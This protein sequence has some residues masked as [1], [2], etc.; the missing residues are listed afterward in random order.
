MVGRKRHHQMLLTV[1]RQDG[2]VWPHACSPAKRRDGVGERK[3]S[4]Y[5]HSQ[6]SASWH[7]ELNRAANKPKAVNWF[8]IY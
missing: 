6:S 4:R 8:S 1:I 5:S 3:Q 7:P 2:A